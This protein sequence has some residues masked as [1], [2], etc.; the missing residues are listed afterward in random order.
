VTHRLLVADRVQPAGGDANAV[1]I[2]GSGAIAGVGTHHALAAAGRAEVTTYPG[3]VILP[4]LRDAHLHPVPYAALLSG[5]TLDGAKDLDGLLALIRAGAGPG[6]GP[7]VALRLDDESLAERRLPTRQD[8]DRAV[9]D[10]PVLV[11]RYC[12]HVGVAN[13]AALILAGIDAATPDPDGGIIDRDAQG[14]PTGVLRETAIEGVA[15][16]LRGTSAVSPSAVVDALNRLV[17]MGITS[18]GAIVRVG[19][20][21]WASLGNEAAI[22][23][24]AGDHLPLRVHGFVSANSVD[25]LDEGRRL[26]TDRGD[27]L[28]WAGLKRFADGGLGGHTAAMYEPFADAPHCGTLRLGTIDRHLIAACRERGGMVAVHAIGDRACAEVLDLLTDLALPSGTARIEHASVIRLVDIERMAAAG[29]IGCVQPAFMGSEAEWLERR[30]G[31]E[32]MPMTYPFATMAAAGVTL[33]AGSDAPVETADPWSGMALA[34]DRNGIYPAEAL[35]PRGALD[36]FTSGAAIALGQPPPLAPGSPADLI[37]VD[38]DPL[39]VDPVALRSTRVEAV[40][41]GGREA[42]LGA[43]QMPTG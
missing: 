28:R 8:L 37:V 10:R 7:V 27:R 30:V 40:W 43:G 19:D 36:L 2:D 21:P 1:L 24:E 14:V 38:R 4:G 34:R 26:L 15:A 23:G 42:P 41:I 22:L 32:R 12:G 11:H 29:I 5:I 31:A 3:G 20:G 35:D 9:G 13:T 33:A 39:E 25:E 16:A 18:I 17:A 6:D